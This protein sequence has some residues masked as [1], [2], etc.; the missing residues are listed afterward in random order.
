MLTLSPPLIAAEA[1]DDVAAYLRLSGDDELTL[2]AGL[3][4]TALLQC[5]AFCGSVLLRRAGTEYLRITG[6]WQTIKATPLR[7]IS[8]VSA[9][10]MA[11]EPMPIAAAGYAIDIDESGTGWL[12]IHDSGGATRARVSFEA[13]SA[14]RW[15]DIAAPLR[16]GML[17]LVAHL[18]GHRDRADDAGPP[19]A[20]AALWRS[21][22]QLRLS[23]GISAGRHVA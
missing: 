6:T 16:Q 15:E 12:R 5:E 20:V 4:G 7:S 3:L 17:R 21:F 2:L 13:G 11:G 10:N 18:H 22:R 19:A 8:G 9:L 23:G 1:L 14:D